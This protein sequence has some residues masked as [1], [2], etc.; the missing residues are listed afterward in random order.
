M[1]RFIVFIILFLV[2][3]SNPCWTESNIPPE[4]LDN[5]EIKYVKAGDREKINI[6]SKLS[7]YWLEKLPR[8]SVEYLKEALN[9]ARKLNDRE[10]EANLLARIGDLY[11]RL[12]NTTQAMEYY[13]QALRTLAIVHV[14]S[15]AQGKKSQ[16]FNLAV[17]ALLFMA[18]VAIILR[19]YYQHRIFQNELK[20]REERQK[21]LQFE[22]QLKVFQSRVNPHFLFNALDS[23]NGLPKRNNGHE[24]KTLIT[25]LAD[26]YRG[27]FQSTEIQTIALKKELDIIRD[28]LEIEKII[29]NNRLDYQ[30][31]VADDL[32]ELKIIPLLI[33]PLIENA[34]IHGVKKKKTGG[35]IQIEIAKNDRFLNITVADNGPGFNPF[36]IDHGFGLYSVQERLKLFYENKARFQIDSSEGSGTKI[37]MEVPCA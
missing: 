4:A 16:L 17:F 1:P 2:L 35:R 11:D 27:I 24:S 7:D 8:R 33:L 30:I 12:G 9:L 25:R 36:A 15:K 37:M 34:I 31:A 3:Y 26:L 32:L 10:E 14:E 22:S 19:Y 23:I 5:F 13:Q 29:L 18:L 21:N 20:R 6:L 28:Y